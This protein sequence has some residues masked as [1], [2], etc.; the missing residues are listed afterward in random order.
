MGTSPESSQGPASSPKI[1]QTHRRTCTN[2]RQA[3][4]SRA[5]AQRPSPHSATTSEGGQH[6]GPGQ[7]GEAGGLNQRTCPLRLWAAHLRQL[8]E[9][10]HGL[11]DP[12]GPFPARPLWQWQKWV[13]L[14]RGA[15]VF[16]ML[17][18]GGGNSARPWE[19]SS[20][21][22]R[23]GSKIQDSPGD[24]QHSSHQGT[25]AWGEG[26]GVAL[27]GGRPHPWGTLATR[28]GLGEGWAGT[29]GS[30]CGELGRQ[31]YLD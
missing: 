23:P 18:E 24:T 21:R 19:P 15:R 20:P 28:W 16:R 30:G 17:M 8:G 3:Q 4:V 12:L 6:G 13:P 5:A 26:L 11:G 9:A 25:A 31:S 29:W 2:E 10:R 27:R 7:N 14:Q 22:D 1:T